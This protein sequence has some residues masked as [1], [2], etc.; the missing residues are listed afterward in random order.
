MA[1]PQPK[2]EA[3]HRAAKDAYR[4]DRTPSN[5]AGLKMA[6]RK[7]AQARVRQAIVDAELKIEA[8]EVA[9]EGVDE[10]R[11]HLDSILGKELL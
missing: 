11:Q 5:R 1:R 9:E 2:L 6:S 10:A 8:A 3:A 7:L 4:A